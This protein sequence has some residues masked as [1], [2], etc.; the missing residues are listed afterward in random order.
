M[1]AQYLAGAG[2][3][4]GVNLL[5]AFGPPTW[6]VLVLPK[7]HWHSLADANLGQ[8]FR[9]VFTS[10]YSWAVEVA[11][12]VGLVLLARVDWADW[13]TRRRERG[14]GRTSAP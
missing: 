8:V 2:I 13:L 14:A 11:M 6:A 12:L 5:P 9:S 10:P 4:W 3:V 1:V 7:L